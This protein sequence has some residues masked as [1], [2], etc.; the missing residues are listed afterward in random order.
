MNYNTELDLIQDIMSNLKSKYGI[1]FRRNQK[2]DFIKYAQNIFRQMGYKTYVQEKVEL[3]EYVFLNQNL[4]IGDIEKAKVIMCAHYDTPFRSLH[5]YKII[6]GK[7]MLKRDIIK[8][9][10]AI[11]AYLIFIGILL[12]LLNCPTTIYLI[13]ITLFILSVPNKENLNDNTSGVLTIFK[14]AAE[15]KELNSSKVAFILFDNEEW[16]L[17]GSKVFKIQN[18]DVDNKLFINF[19]CVGVGDNI[20]ITGDKDSICEAKKIGGNKKGIKGKN[21][22]VK[23]MDLSKANSDE[24]R[25]K[26]RIRF[27]TFHRNKHEQLYINNIHTKKIIN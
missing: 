21:I 3:S 26:N 27:A 16:G 14:I 24:R 25:F 6:Y 10:I 8:G 22:L 17:I 7:K 18:K 23:E 13:V 12:I 15:L 2:L 9:G 4:I 5:R 1:R 19:D 11:L 20:V